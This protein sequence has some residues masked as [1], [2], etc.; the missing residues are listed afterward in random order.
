MKKTILL[1]CSFILIFSAGCG[2]SSEELA[3]T[4]VAQTDVAAT[5]THAAIPID[6]LTATLTPV[7]L[8]PSSTTTFAPMQTEGASTAEVDI[9]ALL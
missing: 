7:P 5:Q 6:T 8:M 3:V 2:P 9:T 1:T 4:M